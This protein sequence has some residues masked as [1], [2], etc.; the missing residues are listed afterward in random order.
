[1][2]KFF[3]LNQKYKFEV[4]DLIS[5]IYLICACLG[6]AGADPTPLFAVGSLIGFVTCF[7]AHRINLVVLNTA[8]LALNIF[9]LFS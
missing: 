1:M 8:L 9:N 4:N 3:E 5:L 7:S 6:I 2:I